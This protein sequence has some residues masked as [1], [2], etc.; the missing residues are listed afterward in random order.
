MSAYV[1]LCPLMSAYVRLCPFMSAYVR[2]CPSMSAYIRLCSALSA[3]LSANAPQIC[4]ASHGEQDVY[5]RAEGLGPQAP[6]IPH[7][8]IFDEF[9]KSLIRLL[10]NRYNRI[11]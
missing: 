7:H 9:T 8:I 5:C 2:I 3:N 4:V 1:R 11:I 6:W 10:C